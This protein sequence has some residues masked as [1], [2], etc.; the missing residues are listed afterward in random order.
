VLRLQHINLES[1][2]SVHNNG[3]LLSVN[4]V[5]S[6]KLVGSSSVMK[7]YKSGNHTLIDPRQSC[8][9]VILTSFKSASLNCQKCLI[10]RI[11]YDIE[12]LEPEFTYFRFSSKKYVYW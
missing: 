2:S 11:N 7:H 6:E 5:F 10:W 9:T 8:S 3:P 4:L 12:V 1:Q